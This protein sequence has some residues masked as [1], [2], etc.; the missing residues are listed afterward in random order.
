MSVKIRLA[1]DVKDQ[2]IIELNRLKTNL[3]RFGAKRK[4]FRWIK[5]SC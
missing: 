1:G 2:R 5:E 4:Y 3:R